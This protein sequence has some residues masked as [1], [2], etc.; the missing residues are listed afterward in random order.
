MHACVFT[1]FSPFDATGA[2]DVI[3]NKSAA[4][5]NTDTTATVL[6]VQP[7][8]MAVRKWLPNSNGGESEVIQMQCELIQEAHHSADITQPYTW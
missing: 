1:G 4:R 7:Y 3:M 5:S 8:I 6:P 2:K